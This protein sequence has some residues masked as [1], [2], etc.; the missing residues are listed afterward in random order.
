MD[1]SVTVA[2]TFVA[3]VLEHLGYVYQSRFLFEFQ[4]FFRDAG[5][6]IYL[7]AAIGGV[8]AVVMYGS[9][10]AAQYFLIGPA[11]FWFLVGPTTQTEGVR[12]KIGGGQFL[13]MF[14]EQGRESS[15]DFTNRVLEKMGEGEEDAN[16]NVAIGFYLF[17]R[18]INDIVNTMADVILHREDTED[19]MAQS[20]VQGLELIA[21][22]LPYSHDHINQIEEFTEQCS[23]YFNAASSAAELRARQRG[24]QSAR[25]NGSTVED[26]T[27]TSSFQEF[28]QRAI[29]HGQSNNVRLETLGSG[30][31]ELI[32]W[33][34]NSSAAI[35]DAGDLVQFANELQPDVVAG[36]GL[37][38]EDAWRLLAGYTW[39]KAK[40]ETDRLIE[41][42]SGYRRYLESRRFTCTELTRKTLSR[43]TGED[44]D[45][46]LCRLEPAV[47]MYL[48]YNHWNRNDT[49]QR[50]AA[51]HSNSRDFVNPKSDT[52]VT[53]P[54]NRGFIPVT[55]PNGEGSFSAI[56]KQQFTSGGHPFL[57]QKMFN[58]SDSEVNQ[59]QFG[60][61]VRTTWI[62]IAPVTEL[63]GQDHAT[64]VASRQYDT[65]RLKQQLFSFAMHLPYY[66]GVCLYFIAVAYPFLALIVLLPGKAHNFLLVPFAWA[67]IKSWDVGFA[68]VIVLD[69][70]MYNLLPNWTLTPELRD[71]PWTSTEQLIEVLAQGFYF[72]PW[73]S[74]HNYYAI[75]AAV[76]LGIP[77]IT[78]AILMGT[79]AAVLSSFTGAPAAQAKDRADRAA[80]GFSV[81]VQSE[82]NH[83]M[84]Q[85]KGM[86]LLMSLHGGGG[87]ID[88]GARGS[89]AAFYATAQSALKSLDPAQMRKLI[90]GDFEVLARTPEGATGAFVDFI[91][92]YK[93]Q[94]AIHA[95]FAAHFNARWDPNVG[96]AGVIQEY[97]EAYAAALEN[98]N[99]S[100]E[101]SGIDDNPHMELL[102]MML[103]QDSA[104]LNIQGQLYNKAG[105]GILASTKNPI[106][107]AIAVSGLG[108][109]M[110]QSNLTLRKLKNLNGDI[111]ST[112]EEFLFSK[113]YLDKFTYSD[114]SL[115]P[116]VEDLKNHFDH[117]VLGQVYRDVHKILTSPVKPGGPANLKELILDVTALQRNLED[118]PGG[119]TLPSV[120]ATVDS[121][122][123]ADK[124]DWLQDSLSEWTGS[125]SKEDSNQIEIMGSKGIRTFVSRSKAYEDE[126][127][128]KL[129]QYPI[130]RGNQP[131]EYRAKRIETYQEIVG[132][133]GG[134][135]EFVSKWNDYFPQDLVENKNGDISRV[136][137]KG[138]L[139]SDGIDV[140]NF[141]DQLSKDEKYR[142]NYIGRLK[143]AFTKD[144]G[145][146][147]VGDRIQVEASKMSYELPMFKKNNKK[148]GFLQLAEQNPLVAME[149]ARNWLAVQNGLSKTSGIGLADSSYFMYDPR[150]YGGKV[151]K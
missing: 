106:A 92:N 139:E 77:A 33:L 14:K 39:F 2:G 59:D 55:I 23:D 40:A 43:Q 113:F 66:Q 102:D 109:G 72:D 22:I 100:Y 117:P 114:A 121:S 138:F 56:R 68:A 132:L 99:S 88:Q 57:Q 15:D 129:A 80:S 78:G 135:S 142:E 36:A 146:Y 20:K 69:K 31:G 143:D 75:M 16:I 115:K 112:D 12:W 34:V 42:G 11:L 116:A 133:M 21:N 126:L 71:G 144:D 97:E 151:K 6:L 37:K 45:S 125:A 148:I 24:L 51:R 65:I 87:R 128:R 13:G 46:S 98:K 93:A 134:A 84:M 62:P 104:M 107:G 141:V 123:M 7:L 96:R 5:A 27:I 110:D 29:R 137:G 17:V 131:A 60:G 103:Q 105:Y 90:K 85:V 81:Q 122:T 127:N 150:D 63:R 140:L 58:P 73:A 119:L 47:T 8:V 108:I 9:T 67:W 120:N 32:S 94:A 41:V 1:P 35:R 74:I 130:F 79:K 76:T 26:R 147:S 50:V 136:N 19:L 4:S 38:C 145:V 18:P 95:D 49:F 91:K 124:I 61:K 48:L 10:R 44:D 64:N 25:S 149:E 89:T 118:A 52:I 3:S 70:V 53:G 83:M 28:R 86:A 101:L 54:N 111:A 82:R 30:Y